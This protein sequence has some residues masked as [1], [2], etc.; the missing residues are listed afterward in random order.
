MDACEVEFAAEI[1]ELSEKMALIL[2]MQN[3]FSVNVSD[4]QGARTL[5]RRLAKQSSLPKSESLRGLE[6]LREAW[7]AYDVCMML[8]TR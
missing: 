3:L 8:A 4:I 6:L 7:D 5:V 2:S 1:A